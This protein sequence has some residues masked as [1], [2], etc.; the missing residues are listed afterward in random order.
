MKFSGQKYIILGICFLLISIA[1]AK[2]KKVFV[3]REIWLPDSWNDAELA[4]NNGKFQYTPASPNLKKKKIGVI[5]SASALGIKKGSKLSKIPAN[6][7]IKD[8]DN[9]IHK[10]YQGAI[11]KINGKLFKAI[12]ESQGCIYFKGK[13]KDQYLR[14]DI[15]D[16]KKYYAEKKKKKSVKK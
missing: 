16:L 7:F 4:V 5:G 14:A 8:K 13:V 11:Y 2:D 15:V 9:Q 12:G 3:G 6:T 10:V 1:Q